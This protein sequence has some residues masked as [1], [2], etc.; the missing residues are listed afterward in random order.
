MVLKFQETYP[1]LP[2]SADDPGSAH[3]AAHV[4]VH[5]QSENMT[6]RPVA[7]RVIFLNKEPSLKNLAPVAWGCERSLRDYSLALGK[8][9]GDHICGHSGHS[10]S[11]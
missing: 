1:E 11:P 7:L 9:V 2:A 3:V 6:L 5:D 10:R 8:F 4:R